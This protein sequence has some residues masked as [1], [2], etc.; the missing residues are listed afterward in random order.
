MIDDVDKW[1]DINELRKS[2][3]MLTKSVPTD[4]ILNEISVAEQ[5]LSKRAEYLTKYCCI[6]QNSSL[7]WL[8]AQ[9]VMKCFSGEPL[10]LEDFSRC[11]AVAGYDLSQTTDLS[12]AVCVIEKHER[13]YVFAHFWMP[14]NKLEEATARDG[15]PYSA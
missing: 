11:Y 13:L 9:D 7:A 14:A 10:R 6:K 15:G 3:P 1:N 5:S 12:A 2:M 4:Y 8:T